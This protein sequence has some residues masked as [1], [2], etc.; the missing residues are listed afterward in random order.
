MA[1]FSSHLFCSSVYF[2]ILFIL[3]CYFIP[4]PVSMSPFIENHQLAGLIQV[5]KSQTWQPRP[6]F[7]FST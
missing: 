6:A 2:I 7:P 1:F 5:G 3:K 4:G